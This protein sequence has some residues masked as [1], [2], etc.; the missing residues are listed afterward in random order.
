MKTPGKGE[1]W[2]H[3]NGIPYEIVSIANDPPA[4]N[5]PLYVIYRGGNGKYWCRPL[6]D[7]HRSFTLPK[8]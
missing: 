3:R 8:E 4:E 5:H 1:I 6:S 2:V 7:W